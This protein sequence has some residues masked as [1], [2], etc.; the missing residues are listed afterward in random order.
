MKKINLIT[1]TIV[2]AVI[3][4]ALNIGN[5]R[6]DAVATF[7]S[8]QTRFWELLAGSVLAQSRCTIPIFAKFKRRLDTWLGAIGCPQIPGVNGSMLRNV[9]SLSGAALIT[10]GVLVITKERHFP[11]WWAVLPTLGTVLVISAGAQAWLNRVVLS[12]RVLVW[13][14]LISFPLYLWHWPLLSFAR[15]IESETPSSEIRIAAVFI[16]IV[17]A[18]LTYKLIEEPIRFGKN[19]AAKTIALFS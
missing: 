11:G 10:I 17:L 6:S 14:G 7:Y 3:S 12:R 13:V 9:Q 5:V 15:I 2:I 16:A 1:I 4:F 19:S 18:W 8:P